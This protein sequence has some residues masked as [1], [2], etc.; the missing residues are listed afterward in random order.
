M[1]KVRTAFVALAMLA[2]GAG[3]AQ[4]QRFGAQVSWADDADLGLGARME[5]PVPLGSEGA[6]AA[7]YLV[8]SFDYFF[9]DCDDCS[10]IEFNANVAIP[11]N[12][13]SNLN[14]YVGGG[15]NM[16][17]S[18]VE[19]LGESDSD[20]RLGLNALGGLKFAIGNLAS[21]A[22]ARLEL[23]DESQLVLT[24]GVLLGENR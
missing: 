9:P 21:F 15:L 3:S 22:E 7:L 13:T 8:G 18:S 1:W 12:T 14:P 24:F 23:K 4:A 6:L 2:L 10:Y 11:V 16:S 20:T 17:R 19:I 5:V